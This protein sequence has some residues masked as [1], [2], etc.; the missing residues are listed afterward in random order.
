[1]WVIVNVTIITSF[2]VHIESRTNR[3]FHASFFTFYIK[4]HLL[5]F[6]KHKQLYTWWE[7][8][9]HKPWQHKH[10]SSLNGPVCFNNE[11]RIET[12][13][14]QRVGKER[15]CF[16]FRSKSPGQLQKSPFYISHDFN[17]F[18]HM[19]IQLW[20]FFL[21]VMMYQSPL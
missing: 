17:E 8:Y 2:E 16:F 20:F 11:L 4:S 1:M 10:I 5:G 19:E 18:S 13:T 12:Q 3:C 7:E 14:F 21:L 15:D 6:T 9:W